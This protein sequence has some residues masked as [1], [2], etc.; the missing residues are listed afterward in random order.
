MPYRL[1]WIPVCFLGFCLPAPL[2]AACGDGL[3]A[4]YQELA[5]EEQAIRVSIQT[6]NASRAEFARRDAVLNV[7]LANPAPDSDRVLARR[8]R[9][10]HQTEVEP[11]RQMIERLRVQHE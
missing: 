6:V 3:E 11:K 4:V 7:A 2:F 1:L 5:A 10:L 9:Q 8:L